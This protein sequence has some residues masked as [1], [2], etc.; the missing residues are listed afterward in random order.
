MSAKGVRVSLTSMVVNVLLVTGK[1]TTGVLARSQALVADGFHSLSDLSTDLVAL[2]AVTQAAKPADDSHPYGHGKFETF[3]ALV[4]GL[5]LLISGIW[6]FYQGFLSALRGME[7]RALPQPGLTALAVALLSMAAKEGL[8]RY[9]RLWAKRLRSKA[10]EA[11]A[12]HQRS[13]VLS[14]LAVFA[15]ICG[16]RFLGPG[17]RFLDPLTAGLVS[18]FIL[19]MGIRLAVSSTS[20]LLE[21]SL[22]RKLVAEIE[23]HVLQTPGVTGCHALKTRH[24][25]KAAVIDLH[26]VM[27]AG[28]S[29]AEAHAIATRV[30][31]GLRQLLGADTIVNVHM[32]PDEG[33]RIRE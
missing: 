31:Q 2:F 10:L 33:E 13:D 18:L 12:L 6:M 29:L 32:E 15:G 19:H 20:E 21:T 5:I 9:S 23:K 30:E 4:I 17:W 11:N 27:D 7:G 14:S 26:I 16:A 28:M 22:N 24:V 3:S 8:Y 1:I 25:G